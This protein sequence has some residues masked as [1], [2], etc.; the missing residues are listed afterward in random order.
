MTYIDVHTLNANVSVAAQA[1]FRL[2]LPSA[3]EP[4]LKERKARH[5]RQPWPASKLLLA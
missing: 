3:S 5:S 2:G 4:H 1:A